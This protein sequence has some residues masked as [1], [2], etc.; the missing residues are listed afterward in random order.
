MTEAIDTLGTDRR[1]LCG[2]LDA[3]EVI[4][5]ELVSA[6]LSAIEARDGELNAFVR[7]RGEAALA[8]GR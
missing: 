5:T 7:T 4:V 2:L 1:A 8:D 6:Y 3:G